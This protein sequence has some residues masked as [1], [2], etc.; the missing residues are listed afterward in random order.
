M[1]LATYYE[2]IGTLPRNN[3][4]FLKPDEHKDK[5]DEEVEEALLKL[6]APGIESDD[7]EEE[8]MINAERSALRGDDGVFDNMLTGS[9]DTNIDIGGGGYG[10]GGYGGGGNEHDDYYNP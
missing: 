8:R 1:D 6:T 3:E 7:R 5:L 9:Y 4:I 10:G 2:W